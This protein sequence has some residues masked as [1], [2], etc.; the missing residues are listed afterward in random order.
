MGLCGLHADSET[1]GLSLQLHALSCLMCT[2]MTKDLHRLMEAGRVEV[3]RVQ[4]DIALRKPKSCV[5]E[6]QRAF[7]TKADMASRRLWFLWSPK[8]AGLGCG[9]CGGCQFL[10]SSITR[11]PPRPSATVFT[12][13]H[14]SPALKRGTVS[15][16]L[17]LHALKK[18]LQ[19]VCISDMACPQV[20]HTGLQGY[21]DRLYQLDSSPS[22][23][24]TGS[25]TESFVSARASPDPSSESDTNE[26]Y[27]LENV[28]EA[29]LEGHNL[30]GWRKP[31]SKVEECRNEPETDTVLEDLPSFLPSYNYQII[32][33]CVLS[34]VL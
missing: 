24:C 29:G 26:F 32:P 7:L 21:Y 2:P 17:G 6:R 20:I 13:D 11:R 23:P 9:C 33:L 15:R 34:K 3:G 14:L 28:N 5:P 10:D 31:R 30:P 4:T 1:L 27:S 8:A 18:S 25:D 22:H 12:A 19:T 16:D